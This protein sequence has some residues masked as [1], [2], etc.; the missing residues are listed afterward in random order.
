MQAH[1]LHGSS[2]PRGKRSGR[3]AGVGK[4]RES[5]GGVLSTLLEAD[6]AAINHAPPSAL[7]GLELR[8]RFRPH[9]VFTG[10]VAMHAKAGECKGRG[11]P[12]HP[13]RLCTLF[14]RFLNAAHV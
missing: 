1:V 7:I 2:L 11:N 3:M 6:L 14:P 8:K 12:L 4:K 9:G 5:S 13:V 10:K